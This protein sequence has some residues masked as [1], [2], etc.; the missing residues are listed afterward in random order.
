M[1]LFKIKRTT[2]YKY[3]FIKLDLEEV[4]F[5]NIIFSDKIKN[6][7]YVAQR[8]TQLFEEN[9]PSP[10]LSSTGINNDPLIIQRYKQIKHEYMQRK[11][12]E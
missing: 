9:T 1:R 8:V 12:R 11:E 4:N 5:S 6:V 10:K 7:S 2:M 3:I